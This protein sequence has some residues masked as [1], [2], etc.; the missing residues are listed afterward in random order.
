MTLPVS[1]DDMRRY[2]TDIGQY[3][4]TMLTK[5]EYKLTGLPGIM[6]HRHWLDRYISDIEGLMHIDRLHFNC[7]GI[8]L[9]RGSP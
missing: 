2:F 1:I 7:F 9:P 4:Q 5:A 6:R 3:S 8:E